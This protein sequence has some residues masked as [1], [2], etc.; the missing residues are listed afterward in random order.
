MRPAVFKKKRKNYHNKKETYKSIKAQ[1]YLAPWSSSTLIL[2]FKAQSTAKVRI[3]RAKLSSF[4]EMWQS[5]LAVHHTRHFMLEETY[6]RK[7]W[8]KWEGRS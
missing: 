5:C 3:I 7:R 6:G 4:S 8:M 2:S 1:R